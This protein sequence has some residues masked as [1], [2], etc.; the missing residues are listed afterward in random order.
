MPAFIVATVTI[1]DPDRFAA[2]GRAIAGLSERFGGEP[3]VRG[4]VAEYLE[5]DAAAG[6]RVV[7]TR[8][9]D[10]DAAR[11]YIGSD[12]YR[13]ASR[14]RAGAAIVTMRLLEG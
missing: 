9:P 6:E 8:F 5:G 7:V 11:A 4:P 3:V 13:E 14:E 12:E 1:T 2:Y 10:A